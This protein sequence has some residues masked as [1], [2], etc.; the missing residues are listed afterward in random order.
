MGLHCMKNDRMI[1]SKG[2][3][4]CCASIGETLA[5]QVSLSRTYAPAV[6]ANIRPSAV[7]PR[8]RLPGRAH[9]VLWGTLAG[10]GRRV[11]LRPHVKEGY[12]VPLELCRPFLPQCTSLPQSV[13]SPYVMCRVA[14]G[15]WRVRVP[16]PSVSVEDAA[17][18]RC[19]LPCLFSLKHVQFSREK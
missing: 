3:P 7:H 17:D 6:L 9:P 16:P 5:G 10:E 11:R 1:T 18:G 13:Y 2:L 19:A 4:A 12:S 14:C 15:V 8:Q